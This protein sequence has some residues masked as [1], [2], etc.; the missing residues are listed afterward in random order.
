M[1]AHLLLHLGR[2]LALDDL[3]GIPLRSAGEL[4]VV[5]DGKAALSEHLANLVDGALLT[6]RARGFDDIVGR[7][8]RVLLVLGRF[9]LSHCLSLQLV[10]SWYMLGIRIPRREG[11]HFD[12]PGCH[13]SLPNTETPRRPGARGSWLRLS[14]GETKQVVGDGDG[15]GGGGR[16]RFGRGLGGI[17]C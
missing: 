9:E 7:G 12:A 10:Y 2:H 15:G 11:L 13:H 14:Q 3:E 8:G 5:A 4:A 6:I 1:G 16:G 17:V